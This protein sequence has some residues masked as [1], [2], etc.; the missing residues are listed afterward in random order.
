M[1]L[2]CWKL[3]P[4]PSTGAWL[5]IRVANHGVLQVCCSTRVVVH[6][7][8]ETD[9]HEVEGKCCNIV[10]IPGLSGQVATKLNW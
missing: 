3:H 8:L 4:L 7:G 2:A 6:F 10:N 1:L 9:E 5:Y